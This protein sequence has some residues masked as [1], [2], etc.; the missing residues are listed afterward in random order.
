MKSQ[1]RDNLFVGS[2]CR[3]LMLSRYKGET[4]VTVSHGVLV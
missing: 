4:L 1:A 3:W 2:N